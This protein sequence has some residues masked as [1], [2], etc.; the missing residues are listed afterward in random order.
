MAVGITLGKVILDSCSRHRGASTSNS[1]TSF[2]DEFETQKENQSSLPHVN[3]GEESKR[4]FHKGCLRQR[5]MLFFGNIGGRML[6]DIFRETSRSVES[7]MV[8]EEGVPSFFKP[9]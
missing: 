7:V 6:S 9:K 4:G 1:L 2:F 3:L 8:N 5:L